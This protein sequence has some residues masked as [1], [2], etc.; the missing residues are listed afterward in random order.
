[1]S[2]GHPAGAPVPVS[3]GPYWAGVHAPSRFGGS[4]HFGAH[5]HSGSPA[6]FGSNPGFSHSYTHIHVYTYP[7]WWYYGYHGYPWN[8]GG[9][10]GG[11]YPIFWDN[12]SYDDSSQR[13]FQQQVMRQIDDLGQEVQRLREEREMAALQPP[14][15]Q[16]PPAPQPHADASTRTDLPT[17][18]VYPDKHIEE[19]KNYAIVGETLWIFG[20]HIKKIPLMDIDLA[21][22]SKLNDERGVYFEVPGRR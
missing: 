18:L 5:P 6:H 22:T 21:A 13:D 2:A 12:S 9:Y 11:Y 14:A 4:P 7:S 19:V 8:Y 3:R 1:M 20:D 17:I 10:Y 15:P 16:T